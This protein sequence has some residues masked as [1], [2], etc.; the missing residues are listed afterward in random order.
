LN[1]TSM[2]NM[3]TLTVTTSSSSKLFYP[4]NLLLCIFFVFSVIFFA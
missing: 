1:I 3:T 4:S 2:T